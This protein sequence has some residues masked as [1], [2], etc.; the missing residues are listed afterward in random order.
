MSECLS[1]RQDCAIVVQK[2]RQKLQS[3]GGIALPR[4]QDVP[5]EIVRIEEVAR[6][7]K[8]GDIKLPKFQRA[9]VWR[10]SDIIDLLD[11]V[12]NGYPI[13]SILLW[14]TKQHLASERTI[15]D[16]TVDD[17]P[18]EYPTNYLLDGQQ[19]IST[20][21]G[22]LYWNGSDWKSKW[23]VA[24]DLREEK[25]IHVAD[26][27]KMYQFPLNRLLETRDFLS[28]A[29][30]LEAS[31]LPDRVQLIR[32]AEQLLSAL[33]DYR[34]A[35]VVLGDMSVDEVAP[36]FE[37]INST[38]RRL[39]LV[40]LMRAATWRGDFD[41][42]D[43][44]TGITDELDPNGFGDVPHKNVLRNITAATG[45]GI[46]NSDID[47]L[48]ECTSDTLKQLAQTTGRSYKL[49]VDF[50]HTELRVYSYGFLPY[51]LQLTFLVEFFRTCPNPSLSQRDAL[52]KWFW[53]TAI[54]ERYQ[55]ANTT[56]MSEDL[57]AI[58]KLALGQSAE[59]PTDGGLDMSGF[60]EFGFSLRNAVSKAFAL[61]LA[62]AKPRNLFDGAPISLDIALAS[63][64]R[65]EF[66][67]IFPKEFL[68]SKGYSQEL[69]NHPANI[70]IT[71]LNGNRSISHTAPSTYLRNI[72]DRLGDSLDSVRES[73]FVSRAAWELAE[74]ESYEE[75]LRVRSDDL[76]I[77]A[78]ELTGAKDYTS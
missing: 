46:S 33:K 47:K 75:F 50:L 10:P 31:E 63:A 69:I 59:M 29:R 66:H 17:R 40:D 20:I 58:R 9:F 65:I 55:G 74:A 8:E 78:L 51:G 28:R 15:G 71:N 48:R 30:M 19:R 49:A 53:R 43:A 56:K 72:A 44:I 5:P 6:R 37:R 14:R 64:N 52:K 23:N 54:S 21:C 34:V 4:I 39:T 62:S 16:L 67:H 7:V 2:C 1:V 13:G 45:R 60:L 11:S 77:T 38:G 68:R 61:L 76:T 36:I 26:D 70:C 3:V 24:F 42:D 32:V 41:L 25:F 57:T 27:L 18:E 73:N 35:A 22:A 12:Y